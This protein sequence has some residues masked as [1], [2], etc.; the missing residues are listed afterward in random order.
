MPWALYALDFCKIAVA[1]MGKGED[2][3]KG[4]LLN[5][6]SLPSNENKAMKE[7]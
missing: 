2:R 7:N 3:M 4:Y 5:F 6:V 1:C